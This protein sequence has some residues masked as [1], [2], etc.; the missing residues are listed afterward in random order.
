[1]RH[2]IEERLQGEALNMQAQLPLMQLN[3]LCQQVVVGLY[4]LGKLTDIVLVAIALHLV[5]H[6]VDKRQ[7]TVDQ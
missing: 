6:A 7:Q 5:Y 3:P 4:L 2:H 1:M